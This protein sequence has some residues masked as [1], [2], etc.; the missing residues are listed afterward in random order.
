MSDDRE[1]Y[2][3]ATERL[4]LRRVGPEDLGRSDNPSAQALRRGLRLDSERS[5]T[6]GGAGK[7]RRYGGDRPFPADTS[8]AGAAPR[9]QGR[10]ALLRPATGPWWW[11]G[12]PL[13][14]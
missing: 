1:P 13:P 14:Q 12:R 3:V 11:D 8:S 5:T 2:L 10:T 4:E 7:S 9:P 6:C